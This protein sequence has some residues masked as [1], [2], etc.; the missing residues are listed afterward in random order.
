VHSGLSLWRSRRGEG[1]T[2]IVPQ[3]LIYLILIA[4][5]VV[6]L[7]AIIYNIVKRVG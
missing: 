1:E 2:S 5:I 7:F 6:A 3:K 4:I